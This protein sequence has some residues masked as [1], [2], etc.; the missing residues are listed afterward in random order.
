[1]KNFSTVQNSTLCY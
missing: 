1:M